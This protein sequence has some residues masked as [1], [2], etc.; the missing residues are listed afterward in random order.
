MSVAEWLRPCV[1]TKG[2]RLKRL[3]KVQNLDQENS[4]D[5]IETVSDFAWSN[6]RGFEPHRSHS[7][8]CYH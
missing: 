8:L 4:S 5:Y 1:S 3:D 7:D 2:V 6:P